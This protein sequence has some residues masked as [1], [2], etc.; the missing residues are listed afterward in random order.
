VESP[1]MADTK[2]PLCPASFADRHA[3]LH[4]APIFERRPRKASLATTTF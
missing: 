4:E 1:A 3:T 2:L